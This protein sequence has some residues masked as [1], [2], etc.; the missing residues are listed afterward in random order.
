MKSDGDSRRCAGFLLLV[1]LVSY[2]AAVNL[3]ATG[4]VGTL[5]NL[6]YT[7]H[8][9][10]VPA[11]YTGLKDK[12]VAVVCVSN[13]EAFGPSYASRALASLVGKL[14]QEN[15]AD[16]T[17]IEQQKIAD[18]IDRNDWDYLDYQA[19]GRG[20][21]AEMVVAID[22]DSFSLHEGKTLYKGR[23]DVNVVVYDMTQGGKEVFT[24]SPTQLQFPENAG[25][26]TTDMS[27]EAFRRQF[28]NVIASR[29]ARQFYAYD[30]KED[31][32]RD[33]SVIRTS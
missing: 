31:F 17:L 1:P 18:W 9:N 11:R 29:V 15:V 13:S 26:H 23:A 28:L 6:I 25:H 30:V 27:E 8:G 19:V 4:C 12:R 7:A 24:Y 22:L 21:D 14:L 33:A 2:L 3:A 5:A 32:A 20:V 10:L 16:V